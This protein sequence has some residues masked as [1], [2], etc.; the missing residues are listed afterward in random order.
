[1]NSV[2]FNFLMRGH[3]IMLVVRVMQDP[4]CLARLLT[5]V[6]TVSPFDFKT[7]FMVWDSIVGANPFVDKVSD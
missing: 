6:D 7:N 3:L 2:P 4:T 1:M 5:L